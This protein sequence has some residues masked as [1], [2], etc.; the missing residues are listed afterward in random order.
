MNINKSHEYFYPGTMIY[1]FSY[2]LI[3]LVGGLQRVMRLAAESS[4]GNEADKK[5]FLK[6]YPYFY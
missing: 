3:S 4:G 2:S 5:S 1:T 6:D